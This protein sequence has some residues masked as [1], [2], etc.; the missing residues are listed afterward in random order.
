MGGGRQ[1]LGRLQQGVDRNAAEV[2]PEFG[3]G[4]HAVDVP[5]ERGRLEGLD[6]VPAPHS[7]L[8]YQALDLE[9]P[10]RHVKFRCYLGREDGP[11]GA[12]VVLP[13]RQTRVT[14]G[15]SASGKAP[16]ELQHPVCATSAVQSAQRLGRNPGLTGL[17]SPGREGPRRGPWPRCRCRGHAYHSPDA[18]GEPTGRAAEPPG[19]TPN[20]PPRGPP[21]PPGPKPP[22]PAPKPPKTQTL[23]PPREGCRRR[24][25]PRL[26]AGSEP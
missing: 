14:S 3:P 15:L 5:V 11:A 22:P 18:D 23:G 19:R 2:H 1:R 7:R 9:R 10:G 20:P 16:R 24:V 17:H 6:L 13:G 12:H 25:R 26:P 8:G 4:R 21:P